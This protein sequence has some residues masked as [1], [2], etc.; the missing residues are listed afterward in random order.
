MSEPTTTTPPLPGG[1]AEELAGLS[2]EQARAALDEVVAQLESSSVNLELSVQLWERGNAL[3]DICQA[4]LDG[5]RERIE[6]ARP[7]LG[8]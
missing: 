8:A 5:A 4:H 3:A 7:G 6:A 2:Y 1:S